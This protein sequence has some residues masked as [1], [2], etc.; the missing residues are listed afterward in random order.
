MLCMQV[1][2]CA[3][4]EIKRYVFGALARRGVALQDDWMACP[5]NQPAFHDLSP[6]T[7]GYMLVRHPLLR[8]L[9][10]YEEVR[11]R[12]FWHRL[13]Q[14]APNASF[15]RVVHALSRAPP[16]ELNA[17]F[18]PMWATCGLKMGRRYTLLRVEEWSKMAHTLQTHFAPNQPALRFRDSGVLLRANSLY[19]HELAE[20]ANRWARLDLTM[21]GY[22]PWFPGTL[23]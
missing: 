6:P 12:V 22:K 1:T 4:S 17:H 13:P 10:G 5:H 8:L 19:T 2:K 18:R 15:E 7:R 3:S 23:F 21:F 11:K 14:V 9:S 16:Q 20:V